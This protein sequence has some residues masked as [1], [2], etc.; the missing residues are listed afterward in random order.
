MFKIIQ[1][2][3]NTTQKIGECFA[4]ECRNQIE[5]C[6]KYCSFYCKNQCISKYCAFPSKNGYYCIKCT[7]DHRLI[8]KRLKRKQSN[9]KCIIA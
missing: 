2:N 7:R 5:Q 4:F 1:T 9:E 3:T 6:K 8:N